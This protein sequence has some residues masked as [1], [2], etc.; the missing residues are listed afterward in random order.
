MRFCRSPVLLLT[1]IIVT[2]CAAPDPAIVMLPLDAA[3]DSAQPHMARAPDGTMVLS[4]L[5]PDGN[6][7]ALRY[8]TLGTAGWQRQG[9]VATGNDWFV[10]WADF[11]SVVPLDDTLWAAHWLAKRPGGTY[12]Y[13]VVMSLSTDRGVTW[14]PPVTPH[15]DGTRTEHGFVSLFPAP[16]GVGVVWLDGRNMTEDGHD[17]ESGGAGHMTLRSAVVTDAA[18]ITARALVDDMVCDCCQT[19][20]AMGKTGPLL[21]Y[22]NKTSDEIRDIYIARA[23][24][25]R[26]EPPAAV[27]DDG[28]R[29]P[30]C[31]VNGPAVAAR[32]DTVVVAW[33]TAAND[34]PRVRLARSGNGAESFGRALD[35][36]AAG[37][38]GRVDVD[39]LDDGVAVVSWLRKNKSGDGEICLRTV[40][41][42][43][44]RGPVHVV[45]NT[46][47]ARASGFPQMVRDDDSLVL[48][49]TDTIGGQTRLVSGRFDVAAL[50]P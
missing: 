37:V 29:I 2:A 49:W 13:D 47:A 44:K 15:T 40:A 45:A 21:A 43:G 9:T 35:I 10:N 12:S 1:C 25:G 36:D 48:A 7:V 30:G 19:D 32:D 31:P 23:V 16:A 26:W 22:R 24:D 34:Q 41:P 50:Q 17:H 42:D 11:P 27:A 18:S 28:W 20:V 14:S 4:W 46:T 6:A 3:A 33:F 8:A 5:E 38:I 39:L